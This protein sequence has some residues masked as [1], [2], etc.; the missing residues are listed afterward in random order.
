MVAPQELRSSPEYYEI[1]A[2]WV[3]DDA[4]KLSIATA[5]TAQNYSGAALDG[6]VGAGAI[7]PCAS[8]TVK[9]TTH[10][11][12]Y[13]IT[14]PIVVTGI[15]EAGR[16]ITESLMLTQVNGNETI[17][18]T[19]AFASIISIAVP[20]QVDALGTFKFG[21]GGN[22]SFKP[23]A[24]WFEG[25]KATS[26]SYK[27]K[28][29]SGRAVTLTLVPDVAKFICVSGVDVTQADFPFRVYR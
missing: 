8:V 4:I 22:L 23:P 25:G 10:A 26:G 27:V 21:V 6:V 5:A 12:T 14:D 7:T 24:R 1:T 28:T 11:A 3:D 18:G 20:A 9:T 16:T 15:D 2:T 13:N 29:G 17:T 19:K